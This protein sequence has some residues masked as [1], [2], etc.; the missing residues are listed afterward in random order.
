MST[1]DGCV[2]SSAEESTSLPERG[3]KDYSQG[4]EVE[5]IRGLEMK[6]AGG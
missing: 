1:R 3:A 5:A 4:A 6:K 2:I